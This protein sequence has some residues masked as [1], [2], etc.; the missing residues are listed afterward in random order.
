[1]RKFFDSWNVIRVN[2]PVTNNAIRGDLVSWIQI[3]H[4]PKCLLTPVRLHNVGRGAQ[5]CEPA[6]DLLF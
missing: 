4:F 1:M 2:P 6:V 3:P 5:L